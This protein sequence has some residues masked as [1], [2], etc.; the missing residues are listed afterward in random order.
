MGKPRKTAIR[1]NV[2]AQVTELDTWW[3]ENLIEERPLKPVT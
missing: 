3:R 1:T 2:F